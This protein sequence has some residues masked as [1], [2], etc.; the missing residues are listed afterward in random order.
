MK[1]TS[2]GGLSVLAVSLDVAIRLA[3]SADCVIEIM[4]AAP[5]GWKGAARAAPA[6]SVDVSD[7][8][9]DEPSSGID[10]GAYPLRI[11]LVPLFSCLLH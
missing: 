2:V 8:I 10:S 9:V 11:D 5:R 7:L 1:S 4:A 3:E 6:G